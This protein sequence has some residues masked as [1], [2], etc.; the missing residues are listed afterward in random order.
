MKFWR[1]PSNSNN[2]SPQSHNNTCN[3]SYNTNILAHQ[4]LMIAPTPSRTNICNCSC[5][6]NIL[7]LP[8]LKSK[9]TTTIRSQHSR[10]AS[11]QTWGEFLVGRNIYESAPRRAPERLCRILEYFRNSSDVGSGPLLDLLIARANLFENQVRYNPDV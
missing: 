4:I 8:I 9:V 11:A 3:R 6:T 2:C 7:A 5:N 10:S 1:P